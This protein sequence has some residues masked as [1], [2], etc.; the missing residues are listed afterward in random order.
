MIAGRKGIFPLLLLIIIILFLLSLMMGGTRLSLVNIFKVSANLSGSHFTPE[1]QKT[2]SILVN[3][4]LPRSLAA[5]FAGM[6]LSLSGAAMQGLFQNPMASPD[7]LGVSA[8]SSLGAVLAVS[9]GSGMGSFFSMPLFSVAGGILAALFVYLVA[10]RRGRTQLLF[11]VL[12]GMA[13][14]SLLNGLIS[15]I[16]LF[17]EQYEVSRFIH[18]T[19]GGLEG[20]LWEQL[21]LPVPII[22]AGSFFLLR[23]SG[24]LN[25][26]SQGEEQAHSLG[27][28][29]ESCKLQLLIFS[30]LLTAMAI[31]L[32][33]PVAFIGL[34]MPHL[35]RLIAG[36][37]HRRLLPLSAL[38]GGA[39]LLLCDLIGRRL[40][41]PYEIKTGII[42]ALIGAP[43]F[44]YLILRYQKKGWSR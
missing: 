26:L 35:V 11:V 9:L 33:G 24:S 20:R 19:M 27:L 14:S 8:G 21:Y 23:L 37:D 25:I 41:A 10:S 4:R 43:Y 12:G 30:T 6:A 1:L 3:L 15:S 5:L 17:S 42:T 16:L 2:Y 28:N 31:S 32:A 7:V 34:L 18:W 13:L 39:Y 44:I 29:V 36:A 40:F 38:A 22:L